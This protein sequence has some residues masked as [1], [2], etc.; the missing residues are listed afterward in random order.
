MEGTS[1]AGPLA[2]PKAVLQMSASKLLRETR[3]MRLPGHNVEL[4]QAET[5]LLFLTAARVVSLLLQA[6]TPFGTLVADSRA[7]GTGASTEGTSL[8]P[9]TAENAASSSSS[10]VYSRRLWGLFFP[11]ISRAMRSAS[12]S[13]MV[14][15]DLSRTVV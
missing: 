13:E 4:N 11:S 15:L 6:G 2:S 5:Y 10:S 14:A 3:L 9:W 12:A 8:G 7:E 1:F